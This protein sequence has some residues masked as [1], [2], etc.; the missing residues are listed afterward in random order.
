MSTVGLNYSLQ[1]L[2]HWTMNKYCLPILP[3]WPK[4]TSRRRALYSISSCIP[5]SVSSLLFFIYYWQKHACIF[6]E[7]E[8]QRQC[9]LW[10]IS[11]LLNYITRLLPLALR[12][13]GNSYYKLMCAILQDKLIGYMNIALGK[14]NAHIIQTWAAMIRPSGHAGHQRKNTLFPSG[15]FLASKSHNIFFNKKKGNQNFKNKIIGFPNFLC[16]GAFRV[17]FNLKSPARSEKVMVFKVWLLEFLAQSDMFK[18]TDTLSYFLITQ[19]N[20]LVMNFS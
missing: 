20:C 17:Y 3:K 2:T 18:S 7:A 13:K 9:F 6:P 14:Q 16:L 1:I 5:Q 8:F 4:H 11:T 15:E 19:H 10:D 12:G